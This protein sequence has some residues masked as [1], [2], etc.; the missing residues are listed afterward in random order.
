MC[1]FIFALVGR[2][3]FV[4]CEVGVEYTLHDSRH[5]GFLSC[6]LAM[7][8]AAGGQ[9]LEYRQISENRLVEILN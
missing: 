3:T 9:T 4:D 6:K 7:C 8:Y 5:V 2:K 1:F